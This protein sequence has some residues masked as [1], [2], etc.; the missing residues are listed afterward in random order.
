LGVALAVL[1]I[2]AH[3]QARI[4]ESRR[5]LWLHATAVAPDCAMCR[6]NLATW[7]LDHGD[8]AAAL[9]QFDTLRSRY[10]T[11]PRFEGATGVALAGLGRYP[12]AEGH[13]RRAAAGLSG[14]DSA[15]MRLNLAGALIEQGRLAEGVTEVRRALAGWQ[16]DLAL[17]HLERG[18]AAT[19]RKPVLR[20]ALAELY[21]GLGQ[22]A[23][24]AEQRAA[25]AALHP[26]LA[27][28]SRPSTASA[29][30]Q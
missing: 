22:T 20:L 6:Y 11:V 16:P 26:E 25:L 30:G 1:V 18:V 5:T 15:V 10:P 27:R 13:L 7:L 2:G 19:P 28:V 3:Q 9:A 23:R 21:R 12:E 17:T 29:T 4:W 8:T 14:Q 24:E